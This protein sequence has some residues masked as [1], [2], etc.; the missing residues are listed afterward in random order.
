MGKNNQFNTFFW[1]VLTLLV[2]VLV[3][4]LYS[5]FIIKKIGIPGIFEIE[6]GSPPHND[7]PTGE[8]PN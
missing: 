4:N 5:G 6:F 2:I 8:D 3:Y 1:P 7:Q